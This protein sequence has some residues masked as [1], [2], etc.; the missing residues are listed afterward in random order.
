MI[1]TPLTRRAILFAFDAHRGQYDKSRLPYITHP[2]HVAESMKSEDEC[3]VALLHDVLED[4]DCTVEDLINMGITN[5]QIAALELLCHDDSVPYLEY[6]QA[7][8]VDPIA[9][10][11]KVADL[12]HNSDLT[13]LNL[14]T[15]Q[16]IERIKKYKQAI[17]ILLD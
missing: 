4:T 16:D 7:I 3:V 14:I 17:E 5:R 15:T 2:L 13:R 9:R 10:T 12:N 11:V 6:V 1:Y 8:R